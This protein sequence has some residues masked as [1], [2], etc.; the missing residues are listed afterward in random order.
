MEGKCT[1]QGQHV[2]VLERLR[3]YRILKT[4]FHEDQA[5]VF[6]ACRSKVK[7]LWRT[8][9]ATFLHG[10]ARFYRTAVERAEITASADVR[11]TRVVPQSTHRVPRNRTTNARGG[12]VPICAR[13]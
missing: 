13:W 3:P 11:S 7:S 4:V 12:Y 1:F 10:G 6:V 2:A 9:A 5:E 8:E